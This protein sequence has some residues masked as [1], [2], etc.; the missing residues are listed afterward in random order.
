ME[1]Y[2]TEDGVVVPEVLRPFCFGIEKFP[3][4]KEAPKESAKEKKARLKREKQQQKGKKR[5][6][7][8]LFLII[9]P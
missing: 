9:N 4:V 2:Q 1:N 5:K 7:K 8:Y 3:F 6:M